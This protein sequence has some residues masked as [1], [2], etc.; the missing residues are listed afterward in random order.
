MKILITGVSGFV[1]Q[2]LALKLLRNGHSV[3]GLDLREVGLELTN[4]NEFQ[5]VGLDLTDVKS[6]EQL[7][8]DCIDIL[9]HLA[10]AGVKAV[11]RQW[12][13]CTQVNVIGT[14][15]L[16]QTLLRRVADSD[17]VPRI[18]YTK[19]Y[20]EDHLNKIPVFQE[21]PYIMSK[22]AATTWIEALAPIYPESI[23]I[24]KVFQVYG[25]GD[26]P[27]NVLNY[28][29]R[30]LKAGEKAYFGSGK[31]LR[32]WIYIDDFIN[33][34]VGCGNILERGL[35]RY[36]LGTGERHSI[37]QMVEIIAQACGAGKELLVFD[38]CLDRGDTGIVDWA[39]Q[40]VP[41]WRPHVTKNEGGLLLVEKT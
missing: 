20:Y 34:L 8:W 14:A 33:G 28:A 10:A 27:S 21:N 25:P 15:T 29:A 40:G 7:P 37:R 39:K 38:N 23:T 16:M 5:F 6:V 2:Q 13:L 3:I 18:I 26:D 32:D 9:Y 17:I 1:G 30:T 31:T 4:H 24:A 36:D 19:T 11:A 41:N 12:P 22:V 35:H